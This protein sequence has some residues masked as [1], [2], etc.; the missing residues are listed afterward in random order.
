MN[1]CYR[2]GKFLFFVSSYKKL[3]LKLN[4][5]NYALY[6]LI[7]NLV[8]FIISCCEKFKNIMSVY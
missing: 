3:H 1:K 2:L 8:Y 5:L 6:N 4:I 7:N